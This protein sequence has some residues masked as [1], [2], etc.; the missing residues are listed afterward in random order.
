MVKLPKLSARDDFKKFLGK[1][2]LQARGTGGVDS[3]NVGGTWD[4]SNADRIGKGEVDL[5]NVLIEGAAKLVQWESMYDNGQGDAAAAEI[6]AKQG[7][8]PAAAE[9]AAEP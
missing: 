4:I 5:V 9:P 2:G 7:K 3:A 8:A 6:D 1:M